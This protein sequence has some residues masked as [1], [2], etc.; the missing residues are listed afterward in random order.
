MIIGIKVMVKKEIHQ[1]KQV[2]VFFMLLLTALK[3]KGQQAGTTK[4]ERFSFYSQ[5]SV[6]SAFVAGYG[7]KHVI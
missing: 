3:V 2:I 1:T 5:T 4:E 7:K 6:T